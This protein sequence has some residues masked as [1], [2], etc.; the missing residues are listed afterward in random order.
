M[1]IFIDN[2]IHHRKDGQSII[3]YLTW[4]TNN[5]NM[6]EIRTYILDITLIKVLDRNK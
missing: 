5:E 6:F 4:L 2:I 3:T 1:N